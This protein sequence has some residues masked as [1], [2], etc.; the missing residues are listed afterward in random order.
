M[1]RVV[2]VVGKT[3]NRV[4]GFEVEGKFRSVGFAEQN[5]TG[6]FQAS[7]NGSVAIRHK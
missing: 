4:V 6:R 2:G 3:M 1:G 5:G 7:D